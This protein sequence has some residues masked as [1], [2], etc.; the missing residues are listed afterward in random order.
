MNCPQAKVIRNPFFGKKIVGNDGPIQGHHFEE[1]ESDS[2]EPIVEKESENKS[3]V[4][5]TNDSM[6]DSDEE[7]KEKNSDQIVQTNI[8]PVEQEAL[9]DEILNDKEE[10]EEIQIEKKQQEQTQKKTFEFQKT[11]TK[12]K[13][14]KHFFS[15]KSKTKSGATKNVDEVDDKVPLKKLFNCQHCGFGAL[16]HQGLSTHILYCRQNH[17]R[18]Q[19]HPKKVE[20]KSSSGLFKRAADAE[21]KEENL[22]NVLATKETSKEKG[23]EMYVCS[24]IH[25]LK[26][27]KILY[28]RINISSFVI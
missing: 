26:V 17:S 28:A 15:A 11:G 14:I 19:L 5:D 7:E 22:Q 10:Q 6:V 24:K 9:E 25:C 20:K 21:K 1:V 27:L 12:Q 4:E 8:D 18:A 2:E 16:S 23:T 13:S 3:K